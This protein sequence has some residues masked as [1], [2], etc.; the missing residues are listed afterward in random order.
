MQRADNGQWT[1]ITGIVDPGEH[2][3]RTAVRE[4]QE[5]ADVEVEPVRLVSV[6]VVGPVTHTNGDVASYLDLAFECVHVSG[7]PSPADGENT[8]V[9]WF[10][11]DDH[12]PMNERFTALLALALEDRPEAAF[13]C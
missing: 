7:E 6:D 9:R 13:R 2:P 3:A 8:S 10:P 5:E 11:I 12:P 1:P 4:A